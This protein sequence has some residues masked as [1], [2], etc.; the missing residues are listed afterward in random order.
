MAEL[1][2]IRAELPTLAPRTLDYYVSLVDAHE[3][4]LAWSCLVH[5][6]SEGGAATGIWNRLDRVAQSLAIDDG[7]DLF[8]TEVALVRQHVPRT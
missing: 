2:N 1:E 8:D 4:E 7:D 6:A 3:D 5:A